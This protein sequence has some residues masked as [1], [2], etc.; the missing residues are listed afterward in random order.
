MA[1]KIIAD[2]IQ[3]S[4]AGSLDT[5]YVVNGS[6]KAW[7]NFDGTG[8]IATR[9]SL[10]VSGLTDNGTGDYT[11]TFVASLANVNYT[12]NG[13]AGSGSSNLINISQNRFSYT[14]TTSAARYSITYVNSTLYDVQFVGSSILGDLA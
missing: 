8:T 3:H 10:N 1:G 2:Q 7:A 5:S 9:D 11:T 6:A 13:M 14:P 12:H 4:T